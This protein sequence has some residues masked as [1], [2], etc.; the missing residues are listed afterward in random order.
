MRRR[1]TISVTLTIFVR[2]TARNKKLCQLSLTPFTEREPMVSQKTLVQLLI[3]QSKRKSKKKTP[4]NQLPS[5]Q[6][7]QSVRY[8]PKLKGLNQKNMWRARSS[9]W[10]KNLNLTSR[11]YKIKA[12]CLLE[13]HSKIV[14][15]TKQGI[16]PVD[17]LYFC[18]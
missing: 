5:L 11:S 3:T 6:K 16:I 13:I 18:I 8:R 7:T 17:Y 2:S 12:V 10:L 9:R 15:L 14:N 1:M 4:R